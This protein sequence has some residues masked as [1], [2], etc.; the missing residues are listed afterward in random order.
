MET[1]NEPDYFICHRDD[2]V[3]VYLSIALRA[4]S[5][6]VLER[7]L[8][9]LKKL[10]YNFAVLSL[11]SVPVIEEGAIRPFRKFLHTIRHKPAELKLCDIQEAVATILNDHSL[12]KPDEMAGPVSTV[13]PVDLLRVLLR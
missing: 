12:V 5:E 6:P 8:A 3:L 13:L 2:L 10:R 7:C 11:K 4:D 9:D 1:E